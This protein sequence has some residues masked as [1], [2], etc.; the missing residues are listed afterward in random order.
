MRNVDAYTLDA[1]IDAAGQ[2]VIMRA[3][4]EGLKSGDKNAKM[5]MEAMGQNISII[6]VGDSVYASTD[7]GQTYLDAS[8]SGAQMTSS[9]DQL[10]TMW[11]QLTDAEI[12]RARDQLKD[13][14][15][16][17]E[18]IDGV[19][20]KHITGNLEDLSALGSGT[21]GQEGTVDIWISTEG[22][23]Y[24]RQM[25]IDATSNGQATKGTMRWL[26]FNEDFDITAPPVTSP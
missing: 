5:D 18:T 11:N 4:I 17:T 7:G 1:N 24:I 15:P 3:D 8:A 13:G 6:V 10:A 14:S 12:D 20:T 25:E 19:A 22:T 26:N 23:P 2:T 9:V 16:A 21:G